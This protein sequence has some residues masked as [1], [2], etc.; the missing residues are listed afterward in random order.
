MENF[1][2]EELEITETLNTESPECKQLSEEDLKFLLEKNIRL[3]IDKILDGIDS[4]PPIQEKYLKN[5]VNVTKMDPNKTYLIHGN[6]NCS[7]NKQT[8]WRENEITICPHHFIEIKR[9]DR[10]PFV[11]KHAICNCKSCLDIKSDFLKCLPTFIVKPVL[12]R[13]GC[14][15][16]GYYNW[17]RAFE[18]VPVSCSCKQYL[19]VD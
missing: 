17:K 10:Y 18:Y 8:Q 4:Y 9:Q 14:L 19:K 5:I 13:Q 7:I 12:V 6:T 15:S 3:S 11:I 2:L 1:S 16:N